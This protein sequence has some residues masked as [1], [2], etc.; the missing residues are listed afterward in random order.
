M[1]CEKLW[2]YDRFEGLH[3]PY[4]MRQTCI[5]CPNCY[6]M[7]PRGDYFRHSDFKCAYCKDGTCKGFIV[8]AD[9]KLRV[10]HDEQ[11]F[12]KALEET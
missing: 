8:D 4:P 11:L 6:I 3:F 9:G 12:E 5:R 1:N 2:S 7:R 10:F